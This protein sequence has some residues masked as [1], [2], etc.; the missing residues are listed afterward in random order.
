V[1]TAAPTPTP[2]PLVCT[3]PVANFTITSTGNGSNT[4][5]T[6]RDA[7]TVANPIGCPITDWLWTFTNKG[8]TQSNAQNPAT[9]NYGNN[10]SHSVTLKVTN[11]G[12]F[13]TITIVQ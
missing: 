11:A 1:P 7:S 3:K 13:S 12:G 9:V 4:I 5:Y 8:G 10:S 2:T 6:Y